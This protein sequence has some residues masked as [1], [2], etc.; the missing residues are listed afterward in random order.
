[1]KLK[2]KKTLDHDHDK[3]TTTQEFDKF[4][5]GNFIERLAQ[6]KLVA[7]NDTADFV[8]K[9]YFNERQTNLK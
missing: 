8:K 4:T 6:A 3:Y 7:K 5:A 2:K 9:T 1:M